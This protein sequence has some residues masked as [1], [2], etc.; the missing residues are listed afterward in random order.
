MLLCLPLVAT[1]D[2]LRAGLLYILHGGGAFV[3]HLGPG[4]HGP[5]PQPRWENLHVKKIEKYW[6]IWEVKRLYFKYYTNIPLHGAHSPI[7]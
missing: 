2:H 6:E 7:I 5:H 1:V 4:G 3:W